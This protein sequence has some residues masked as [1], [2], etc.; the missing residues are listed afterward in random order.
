MSLPLRIMNRNFELLGEIDRYKSLQITRSWHGIGSLEL[1]VNRY[2]SGA[3]LLQRGNIVYPHGSPHKAFIIRHREIE[4]DQA[5]KVTENWFI[6]ALP[7]KSLLGQRITYPPADA[8]QD[9]IEADA[10]SVMLHYVANNVVNPADIKRKMESVRLSASL[11]RG[12]SVSWQSRY[13]NLA[14]ELAEIS[15]L[16]GLGWHVDID[17]QAKQ[18]VFTVAEGRDLTVNQS[19]LPPAIF[20]PEFGTL[21]QLGYTESDIN[22]RNTSIVAGQG[23][24]TD[25]RVIETGESSGYDRYELFVDARDVSEETDAE[26]P[27]PRPVADIEADLRNRGQQ[28]LAEYESEV[29]LEGQIATPVKRYDTKASTSFPT[30][31][32]PMETYT[33]KLRRGS[34][35]Y[36]VDYDLGDIV[37]LQNKEW[38]V[39]VDARIT[40]MKEIYEAGNY[41]IEASF[42]NTRP[43]LIEKMKQEIKQTSAEIRR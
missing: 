42:G 29:Y 13:K 3:N 5:G 40:E 25:R 36:E 16:S 11:R 39:T 7:I 32:Q 9:A 34:L 35:V 30:Q 41:R 19:A 38:G 28:K 26:T 8:P 10:E 15:T 23:E 22:Y 1:H 4:L 31:F 12:P 27:Q 18:F 17:V 6:R 37:T 2:I 43:T 20:S 21:R 14:E 33:R 24:G